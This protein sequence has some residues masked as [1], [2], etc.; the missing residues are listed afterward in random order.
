M[1][2]AASR[3]GCLDTCTKSPRQ[4]TELLNGAFKQYWKTNISTMQCLIQHCQNVST[5]TIERRCGSDQLLTAAVVSLLKHNTLKSLSILNEPTTIKNSYDHHKEIFEAL[6]DNTSLQWFHMP[7]CMDTN[8]KLKALF[9]VLKDK[10]KTILAV[11][12]TR[13]KPLRQNHRSDP[14]LPPLI[15]QR[16]QLD[17]SLPALIRH[18]CKLNSM[19]LAVASDPNTHVTKLLRLVKRDMANNRGV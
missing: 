3:A 8:Q 12:A 19:G 13:K 16:H 17:P 2:N 10:N 9:T 7:C 5:I 4:Q 18:R 6:K 14:S 15:R 1:L 11:H